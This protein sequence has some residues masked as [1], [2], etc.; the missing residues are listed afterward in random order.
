MSRKPDSS[1][2]WA[3]GAAV[4]G[5]ALVGGI[6]LAVAAWP[7]P[8]PTPGPTPE[9][10]RPS[11]DWQTAPSYSEADVEAA[12]RMLASESARGSRA[13]HIELIH[14]QLRARKKGQALFDRITAGSGWG[15]QG[16]RAAGG[17]IRPVS[18]EEPAT[19]A[20][21]QLAREVLDGAHPSVLSGARK[22]FEPV[23]QD[24]AFAVAERARKKQAN[25]L[26]L[27]KNEKRLLGY[28]RSA[29][30]VRRGWQAEGAHYIGRIEGFEF[31]T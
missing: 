21:R 9:P 11:D 12:A 4:G 5:T 29:E 8:A 1:D 2:S 6:L 14:S 27:S 19:P 7:R 10:R 18:T 24:R 22:F 25:G 31:Y 3:I 16:E 28:H 26:P 20:L 17:G 30:D 15:P 13:L 23:Q